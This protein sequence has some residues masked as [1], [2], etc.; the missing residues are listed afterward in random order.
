MKKAT[1]I[2]TAFL[3][4]TATGAVLGILYAPDKGRQTRDKLSFQLSKSRDKLADFIEDLLRDKEE[5]MN[6]A[7]TEGQKI[8]DET[9]EQAERLIE[10]IDVFMDK[11]KQ[12]KP[13]V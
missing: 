4:G 9:R 13:Q 2:I 7:K 5:V 6:E 12:G 10:D 1:A 11:I 8:I 3:A